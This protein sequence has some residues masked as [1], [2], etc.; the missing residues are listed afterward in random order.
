MVSGT[1]SQLDLNLFPVSYLLEDL[2]VS[3]DF[4]EHVHLTRWT[5]L[6]SPTHGCGSKEDAESVPGRPISN[7]S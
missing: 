7:I 3:L 5:Y 2:W 6:I 4:P 1:L